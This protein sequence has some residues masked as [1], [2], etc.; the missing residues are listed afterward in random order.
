MSLFQKASDIGKLS[1]SINYNVNTSHPLIQNA[2]EYIYYRK[3]VSVHS[4]D[5]D[6]VK[7]PISSEFEIELPE[8]I[9]NV[10]AI[11]LSDWTFPA[12]YNTF[13]RLNSNT[14]M[15]FIINN[16]NIL[17]LHIFYMFSYFIYLLNIIYYYFLKILNFYFFY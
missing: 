4:E 6:M 2:N 5:R 16:P 15:T 9:V 17:V 3:Y 12:N 7:Y 8:D 10:A 11:R 13:S 1:N 14:I